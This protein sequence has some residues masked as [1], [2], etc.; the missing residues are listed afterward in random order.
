MTEMSNKHAKAQYHQ[1][2]TVRSENLMHSIEY[3]ETAVR[4]LV[5]EQVR[6]NIQTNRHILRFLV[7]AVLCCC[8]QGIRLCGHD[9][10]LMDNVSTLQDSENNP[11]HHTSKSIGNFLSLLLLMSNQDPIP[12]EHLFVISPE[13]T[14]YT[15]FATHCTIRRMSI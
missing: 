12:K 13:H 3:P 4:C 1:D 2:C 10:R 11:N 5:S 7:E 14:K 8:K 15:T 9:E 6:A